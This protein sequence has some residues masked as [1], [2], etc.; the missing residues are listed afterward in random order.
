MFQ[1]MIMI[2]SVIVIVTFNHI[3]DLKSNEQTITKKNR[4]FI[5]LSITFLC[6]YWVLWTFGFLMIT[7]SKNNSTFFNGFFILRQIEALFLNWDQSKQKGK[8]TK[9]SELS[10]S[11]RI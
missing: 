9:Y 10:T 11:N 3:A 5:K 7:L 4:R 6:D 2:I 8:K 1:I